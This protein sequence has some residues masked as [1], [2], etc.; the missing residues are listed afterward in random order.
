MALCISDNV[1]LFGIPNFFFQTELK[2]SVWD[3]W[4]I[5]IM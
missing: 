4:L 2:F 1:H 5:D 3:N